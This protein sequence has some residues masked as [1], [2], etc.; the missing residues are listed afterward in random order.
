MLDWAARAK[1][2]LD[3]HLVVPANVGVQG[4]DKPFDSRGKPVAL[5]ESSFLRRPKKPSHEALFGEQ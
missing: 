4:C 1:R 3:P 5:V 2:N